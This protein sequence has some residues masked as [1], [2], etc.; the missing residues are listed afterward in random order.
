MMVPQRN[1][2]GSSSFGAFLRAL[3]ASPARYRPVCALVALTWTIAGCGATSTTTVGPS[4]VK[5]Q[6]SLSSASN[7]VGAIGGAATVAIATEAECAWT[8]SEELPWLSQLTPASGQGSGQ[9]TFQVGANNLLTARQ[10]DITVNDARFQVVQ[11]AATCAFQLSSTTAT[12][13]AAGG[14]RSITIT[15]L[16]GCPWTAVSQ[17]NWISSHPVRAATATALWPSRFRPTPA[18]RATGR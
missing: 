4:P 3:T 7:P 5:C 12:V 2:P 11:E 9:L 16:A 1:S 8:A 13:S 14:P 6:V 10:G 18:P 15:A 17:A